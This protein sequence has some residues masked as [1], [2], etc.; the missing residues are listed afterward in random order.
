RSR[1][2]SGASDYVANIQLGFDS[3]DG[4]HAATL[5]YN[6]YGKRLYTAGRLGTPDTFEK[7]FNSLDLT[8]SYYWDDNF[9]IKAKLKNLLNESVV[10]EQ[11]G[12]DIYDEEKG[13]ALSLSVQ[14]Q[15]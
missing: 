1:G 12:V 15:Y 5:V 4:K 7:P 13:M 8:Y 11:G 2:L 14:W 6:V 3:D 9:T 10:L